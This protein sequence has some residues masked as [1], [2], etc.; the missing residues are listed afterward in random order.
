LNA[1][2]QN[3]LLVAGSGLFWKRAVDHCLRLE[4]M[5]EIC[6]SAGWSEVR[7]PKF[8]VILDG[9]AW[10]KILGYETLFCLEVGDGHI[11]SDK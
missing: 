8:S 4:S 2:L 11:S 6:M 1:N 3:S 9:L 10:G 7:I 5:V